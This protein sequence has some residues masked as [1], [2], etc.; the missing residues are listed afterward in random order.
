MINDIKAYCTGGVS[1]KVLIYNLW[2]K[3]FIFDEQ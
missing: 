2:K 1:K 3:F